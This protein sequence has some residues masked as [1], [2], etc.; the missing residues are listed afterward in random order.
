MT[1]LDPP[2]PAKPLR[3]QEQDLKG[4]V[5]LVTGATKGIGRAISLDLATRGASILGTYSSPQSAHL[6]DTLTHSINDLY[7]SSP[8]SSSHTPAPS[9]PK[10]VGALADISSPSSSVPAIQEG[11]Q[12]HFNGKV[13]IVIFNAAVMG[14]AKMGDGG[15][16][17]DFVDAAL[18]G[19][20]KFPVLLIEM[21]VKGSM[22]RRDGRVVAI[23]S[24][25]VRARRPPGGAVYAATKAA[26][27]CLMRKWAD[28]LGTHPGMEGTTFNSVSVGFTKTEAYSKIPPEIRDR[29]TEADAAE[30]A[31]GNRIGEVEDV[32]DVVGLL[33]SDKARWLSGSVVDASGGK[34]KI[35]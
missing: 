11:L 17:E 14:L 4:K 34:A 33:I 19:N 24:E 27:E 18:A 13:D 9:G 1:T 25:G 20:V 31:V 29:L 23:S 7:S 12:K 22:I 2:P 16:T 5:A 8:N 6:F 28:E 21:L 3:V 35:L 10:L 32:A 30:V 26:L 15:V